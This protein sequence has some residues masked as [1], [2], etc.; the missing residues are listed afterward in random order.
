[1][2]EDP[3][4]RAL[5]DAVVQLLGS[6]GSLMTSATSSASGRFALGG[7]PSGTYRVR[8]LRIGHS[9]WVSG[10]VRIAA[11]RGRDTTLRL[12]P[13]PVALDDI[14]VTAKSNCRRSP[15]E[16]GGM[17]RLW[18]QAR[19]MLALAEGDSTDDLEF[20]GA[21]IRRLLNA[22]GYPS[23]EGSEF[24]F[25][26]G[27]WPVSS[28]SP[29]SLARLGFVQPRDTLAGPVYYGPDVRSF[30]SNTFLE[31]HCFRLIPAPGDRPGLAGLGF[32]PVKGH[33]VP[34]I[35]GVF[36]LDRI[37][38]ALDRLVFRYARLWN[39]VPVRG[40]GGEI[41]FGRLPG[42]RPMVT[43]WVLRVPVAGRELGPPRVGKR[44][45]VDDRAVPYFG[46]GRVGLY[47]YSEEHARV[48]LINRQGADTLWRRPMADTVAARPIPFVHDPW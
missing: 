4:G 48:D 19:T 46:R 15:D 12:P 36:W 45:R 22:S 29:D 40:A 16:D 34:D 25:S 8:V 27:A 20:R 18:D 9:P 17:A 28:Q 42:G 13:Q 32:E 5:P 41:Q 35:E 43:G 7:V 3:P 23:Q 37:T 1:M 6:D 10:P 47:G 39:W 21:T 26:R 44:R 14:V 31:T 24:L 11:G 38:G 30:F 2:V 33:D